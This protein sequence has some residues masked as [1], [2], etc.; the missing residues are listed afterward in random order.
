M[1][2]E[3]LLE[4]LEPQ[5]SEEILQII[6]DEVSELHPATLADLM[7]QFG[8]GELLPIFNTLDLEQKVAVFHHLSDSVQQHLATSMKFNRLVKLVSMMSHDD[9]VDLLQ[10]L[11]DKLSETV[12]RSLAKAE[13]ED[14]L[15]LSNYEEGTAG[16][17]MTS[18]YVWVYRYNSVREAIKKIKREA[19]D[20]ETIYTIYVLGDNRELVGF[21]SLRELMLAT[22][23][24]KVDDL[25]TTDIVRVM[26]N[27]SQEKSAELLSKYD[28]IAL[29]VMDEDGKLV[30]IIT[31]DDVMDVLE[32]E[33]TDDFHKMGS[34]SL[35]KMN[36]ADASIAAMIMKRLPWL[37]ILV[38]MNIF[39][40]AG[41]AYFENT[42]EAVV[43]LVF[44]LPLLIDSGGNAGSQ[45]ATLMVR[46]LATGT[47]RLADWFRLLGKEI[48][49]ALGIGILMAVAVSGIG[50]YRGGVEVAAVVSITMIIVVLFGSLVGM[51]LPFGLQRFNLD[52]A[53]ASA[54]LVTSIA[55]I[56]GVLIY[57]SI[58]TW[59]LGV[60]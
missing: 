26:A 55:D 14:I 59:Y 20:K 27:E 44:F 42:I 1:E 8:E 18:D 32:E 24:E 13:R 10:S 23:N 54:P 45:A 34:V 35:G 17:V 25:M 5:A 15:R 49:I 22:L 48:F 2:K 57:F 28:L 41:I 56:G 46:A 6:R 43:A 16:A 53:T 38:F 47:V 4:L 9:R 36:L 33:A 29:P 7:D 60:G 50:Y 52:P 19:P 11:D 37:L 58:A 21:V 39:S 40:G 3:K 30:G 31:F 51:S 12:I